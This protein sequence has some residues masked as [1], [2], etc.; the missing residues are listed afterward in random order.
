ML[1]LGL[2]LVKVLVH[3]LVIVS[4]IETVNHVQDVRAGLPEPFKVIHDV[5][6]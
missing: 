2:L 6:G 5:V 3:E 4:F 1:L